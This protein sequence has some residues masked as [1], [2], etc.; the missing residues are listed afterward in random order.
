MNELKIFFL[1]VLEVFDT[2]CYK[3][4]TG[5]GTISREVCSQWRAQHES[6]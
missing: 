4:F 3:L 5:Y 2:N 6:W 1:L